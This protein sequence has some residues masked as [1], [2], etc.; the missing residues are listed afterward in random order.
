M[1]RVEELARDK[2]CTASQLALAWVLAQGEDIVPIR[3][4]KLR[5]LEEN[6]GAV[7]VELDRCRPEAHCGNS[8]PGSR[9]RPAIS[10]GRHAACQRLI[11]ANPE[12]VRCAWFVN[13]G[14]L[15]ILLTGVVVMYVRRIEPGLSLAVSAI[16]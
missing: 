12:E 11:A 5:Y 13:S 9:S 2:G 6:V 15:E 7:K 8:P 3:A 14:D 4:R 16:A 1:K 10:G